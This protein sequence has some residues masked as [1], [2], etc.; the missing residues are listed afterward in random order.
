MIQIYTRRSRNRGTVVPTNCRSTN[1]LAAGQP[2]V[3]K[4]LVSDWALTR[5][6]LRSADEAMAYLRSFYNGKTLSASFG[7]P[8]IAGRLF[9]NED[10]TQ[11]EFLS[12]ACPTW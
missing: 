4:G 5:A 10:F 3:L 8:E 11:A 12:A 7:P 2:R 1:L 6:G 9:Y